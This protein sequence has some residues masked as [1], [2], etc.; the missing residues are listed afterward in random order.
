MLS[1]RYDSF[2][3]CRNYR[4]LAL[5]GIKC[6]TVCSTHHAVVPCESR[7]C[8]MSSVGTNSSLKLS[9]ANYFL[10]S[11]SDV[12]KTRGGGIPTSL[13]PTL[14]LL[15]INFINTSSPS[16]LSLCFVCHL[17]WNADVSG[18]VSLRHCV[19]IILIE[20]VLPHAGLYLGFPLSAMDIADRNICLLSESWQSYDVIAYF[21]GAERAM[22]ISP[23]VSP[24][25]ESELCK[26]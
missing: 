12:I 22:H 19:F 4:H 3:N 21:W 1:V 9:T 18:V 7:S 2:C 6:G 10:G 11:A 13:S 5:L 26:Y 16:H 14:S 24:E 8:C 17:H 23:T 25:G 20:S 15:T